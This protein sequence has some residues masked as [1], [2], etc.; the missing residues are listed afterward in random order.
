MQCL[1]SDAKDAQSIHIS[2]PR[3]CFYPVSKASK[4]CGKAVLLQCGTKR[5]LLYQQTSLRYQQKCIAS[6]TK[7]QRDLSI[8]MPLRQSVCSRGVFF[9]HARHALHA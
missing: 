2:K 3:F 4:I 6:F 5:C 9:M 1:N 7:K 8:S